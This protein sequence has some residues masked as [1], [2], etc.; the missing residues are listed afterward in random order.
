MSIYLSFKVLLGK[1]SRTSGG[2]RFSGL[3]QRLYPESPAISNTAT[4]S[5]PTP[6]T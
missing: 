6:Q 4:K 2:L 1:F 3:L 5:Y